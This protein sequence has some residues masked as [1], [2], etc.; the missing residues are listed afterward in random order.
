MPRGRGLGPK[1]ARICIPQGEHN[2]WGGELKNKPVSTTMMAMQLA[3]PQ[4]RENT[5]LIGNKMLHTCYVKKEGGWGSGN[6]MLC[7]LHMAQILMVK[8]L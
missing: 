4:G 2:Y 7:S 5:L 3:Y 8:T 6:W 1:R